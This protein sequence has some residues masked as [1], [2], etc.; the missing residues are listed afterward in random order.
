[1][2]RILPGA[3]F[4]DLWLDCLTTPAQW[5]ELSESVSLSLDNKVVLMNKAKIESLV[6][7]KEWR[8]IPIFWQQ[9]DVDKHGKEFE[10]I[11]LVW[12][13]LT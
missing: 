7:L 13:P 1:M 6:I 10:P 2:W 5:F 11:S 4:S 3:F 9:G 12:E 8:C